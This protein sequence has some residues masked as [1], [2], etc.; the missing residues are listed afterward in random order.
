MELPRHDPHLP[1]LLQHL[2]STISRL[3]GIHAKMHD[4]PSYS[5]LPDEVLFLHEDFHE[6]KLYCYDDN[7]G[8][9]GS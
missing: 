6:V 3:L 8:Y 2:L 9:E 5:T 1:G 7:A 4:D